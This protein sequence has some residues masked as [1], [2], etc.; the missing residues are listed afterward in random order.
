MHDELLAGGTFR[1][2]QQKGVFP[3]S[4]DSM[5]LADFAPVM[6]DARLWDLGCGSAPL[7]LLLLAR[8]R[9]LHYTGVDLSP[10][11]CALARRNLTQ[12]DLP[13]TILHQNILDLPQILPAQVAE[14][15]ISNPPYFASGK[16]GQLARTG[17]R[18]EDICR[19]A[20]YLLCQGGSFTLVHPAR[21]SRD[22]ARALVNTGFTLHRCRLVYHCPSAPAPRLILMEAV[23][24]GG[25]TPPIQLPHLYWY[26]EDG[27][28][29]VDYKRIYHET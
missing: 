23:K 27:A 3:L 14:L 26:M 16:A 15:V 18:L 2:S 4:M 24:G 7:G 17:C 11:A 6:P 1:L 19:V 25:D 13:G 29:S 22:A 8:E 20:A 12:N 5:A 28:K 9:T 21:Q 10:E